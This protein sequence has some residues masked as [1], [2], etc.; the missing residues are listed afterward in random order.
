MLVQL[1]FVKL[2]MPAL[3]LLELILSYCVRINQFVRCFVLQIAPKSSQH[4]VVIRLRG[5]ILWLILLVLNILILLLLL[6]VARFFLFEC[7]WEL[8]IMLRHCLLV[9]LGRVKV[10]RYSV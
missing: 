6:L 5:H 10:I 4:V 9:F 2:A 8:Q 3:D 7:L 1:Y